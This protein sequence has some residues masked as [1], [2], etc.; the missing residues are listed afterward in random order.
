MCIIAA[1]PAGVGMPDINTIR[2]MW[3]RNNDGAGLMYTD[4]GRVRITKGYMTL[5]SFEA[6]LEELAKTHD[7]T[8]TP[9]VMHFRIRTHGGTNPECTH[10]FPITDSVG[11]LKKLQLRTDIGVAHNGIIHSVTPRTGIS[12]TME[13]IATQLAPLKRAM[14]NFLGN[15]HA[16]LMIQNAIESRMVFLTQSGELHTIGDFIE[17]K[18]VL[19]SNSSYKPWT[20]RAS[21]WSSYFPYAL[22]DGGDVV[23]DYEDYEDDAYDCQPLMWLDENRHYLMADGTVL[24][25]DWYLLDADGGVWMYDFEV[26]GAVKV[27]GMTAYSME[28]TPAR[29]EPD[30]AEYL[31]LVTQSPT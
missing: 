25:A 20:L 21:A 28:G 3:N 19:Y 10:P 29:Y 11:A 18:G 13:Y 24:S 16:R 5:A 12:D 6:A 9:L 1:K 4:G 2:N 7:L 22:E 23:S 15:K 31:P 14:P 27:P 26:D 30:E 17:D 8:A